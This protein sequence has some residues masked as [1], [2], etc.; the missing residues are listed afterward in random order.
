MWNYKVF[1]ALGESSILNG[2]KRRI[3][4]QLLAANAASKALSHRPKSPPL[5]HSIFLLPCIPIVTVDII[6][7][8][9]V[10]V[11]A[12]FLIQE[13]TLVQLLFARAEIIN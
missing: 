9:P 4:R 12:D 7:P 1:S 8:I 2:I 11:S 6:V 3:P 5:I 13:V 10:F